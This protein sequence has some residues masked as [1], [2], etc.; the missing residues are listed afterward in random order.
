MLGVTLGVFS[1]IEEQLLAETKLWLFG[2]Q[3][4]VLV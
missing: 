4:G 2:K 3:F 1:L